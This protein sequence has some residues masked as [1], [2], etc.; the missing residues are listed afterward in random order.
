M[1]DKRRRYRA[2]RNKLMKLYPFEPTGNLAR[3]LNTLAYLISGIVGSKHVNLRLVAE[4][5]PDGTKNES[6]IKKFSR[7]LVNERIEADIYF[8]PF[9]EALLANLDHHVLALA[10]DGSDVGHECVTLLVSVIYK[11]RALPLTWVVVKGAK[12]HFPEETHVQLAEQ[13]HELVPEGKDVVFLGDGEFDGIT[14]QATVAGYGWKYVS[15]TAR[16]AQLYEE[17]ECF[18]FEDLWPQ[19]GDCFGIPDVLFTHQTYGPVLAVVWWRIGYKE[20]IYLVSNMELAEEACH[21]YRKRF[22]IETFFSDQKSR[23]F[24]LHKSHISDPERLARFMIAACL[25]Y[26][27]IIY[28]GVLAKRDG[29]VAIIH[30]PDRCDLSLFQLGLSLLSHFLDECMVIPVAFQMP[31][32]TKSVR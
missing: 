14:F 12:G 21:W 19:P 24:R 4:E 31:T 17:G 20:P 18:S 22:R 32:K 29:W 7:W 13:V 11:K 8:L 2:V 26:I 25:A 3:H 5:V 15:R 16:N 23:G 28:L 1:S 6:R 10:I 9:A 27:W 30:R